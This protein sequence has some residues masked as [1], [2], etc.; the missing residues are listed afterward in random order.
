MYVCQLKYIEL[1]YRRSYNYV[2]L[3]VL[4]LPTLSVFVLSSCP[5]CETT[6]LSDSQHVNEHVHRVNSVINLIK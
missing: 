2:S 6:E 5:S 4:N 1:I 3:L